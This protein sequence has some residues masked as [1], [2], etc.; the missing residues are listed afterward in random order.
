M[1]RNL[2]LF[3]LLLA[4]MLLSS[5][6]KEQVIPRSEMAEIYAEMFIADQRIASAS[7]IR[8]TA[9]TSLVYEPIFEKYGYTSDD[10]R[11]SVAYYIQDATRYARML[12]RSAAII[13]AKIRELKK[14]K[15]LLDMLEDA[16]GMASRYAPERIY[17]LTGLDNPDTF[18]EDSL[19]FYVD[20][21]GGELWFDVR[22]W[23]DTAYFGPVMVVAADFEEDIEEEGE[24]AENG[25]EEAV[26]EEIDSVD[27]SAQPDEKPSPVEVDSVKIALEKARAASAAK[28][29]ANTPTQ[30]RIVPP[31]QEKSTVKEESRT[32]GNTDTTRRHAP[33]RRPPRRPVRDSLNAQ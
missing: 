23:Q 31:G 20:S 11:A 29:D 30:T 22:K 5:C 1:K 8:T 13:E 16:Q 12:K 6:K 14:E 19:R 32:K 18:G 24:D 2:L 7:R 4:V 10:Y 26:D 28:Q 33:T 21:T 15:A 3:C 17:Y 25:S 27:D 9:D